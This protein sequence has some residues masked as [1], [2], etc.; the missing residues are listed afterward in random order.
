M[1]MAGLFLNNISPTEEG[2]ELVLSKEQE[3][4]C[5]VVYKLDEEK[6]GIFY[7][8]WNP[9]EDYS[10]EYVILPLR[11]VFKET[12]P[13]SKGTHFANIIGGGHVNT[14]KL[15]LFREGFYPYTEP[16]VFKIFFTQKNLASLPVSDISIYN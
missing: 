7:G 8:L 12:R 4:Y 2:A 3:E 11:S 15:N 9:D 5:R 16:V 10:D 13:L 14:L 1:L 6:N